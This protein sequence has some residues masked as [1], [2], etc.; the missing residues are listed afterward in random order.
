MLYNFMVTQWY[1]PHKGDLMELVK[2][3]LREF[4]FPEDLEF[5]KNFNS[6]QFKIEVKKMVHR[7][8]IKTVETE[9]EDTQQ[10]EK[11]SS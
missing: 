1:K 11:S 2:E 5:L 7:T 9:A 3:N 10:D 6:D 8:I 4:G